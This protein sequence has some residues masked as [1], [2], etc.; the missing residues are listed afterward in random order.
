M[1]TII[2]TALQGFHHGPCS[3]LSVHYLGANL[4]E[5]LDD[6]R[7]EYLA[8]IQLLNYSERSGEQGDTVRTWG[9][10]VTHVP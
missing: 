8:I 9:L 7:L 6:S 2:F 10:K 5:I 4:Y 1:G 3:L